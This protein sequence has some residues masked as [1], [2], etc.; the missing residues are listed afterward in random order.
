M[1]L[2]EYSVAEWKGPES[3]RPTDSIGGH[4]FF[5]PLWWNKYSAR[6]GSPLKLMVQVTVSVGVRSIVSKNLSLVCHMM[7]K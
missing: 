1:V 4:V 5:P 6:D 7:K 3:A 2:A